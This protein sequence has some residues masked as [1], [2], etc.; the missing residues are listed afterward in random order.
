MAGW[1]HRC[2][3]VATT[4]GQLAQRRLHTALLLQRALG[5]A[6]REG[7]GER[8]SCSPKQLDLELTKPVSNFALN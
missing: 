6:Q 1:R 8:F 7:V 3:G 2:S 5:P 4:S